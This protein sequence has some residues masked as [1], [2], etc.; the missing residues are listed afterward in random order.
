[1]L[2]WNMTHY[3]VELTTGPAIHH[4]RPA[5]DVLFDSAVK[6]GAGAQTLAILLTGMGADGADGMLKLLK[7][8]AATV[9]QNEETCV[10]FGMP[11]EAIRMGAAQQVLPLDKIAASIERFADSPSNGKT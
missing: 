4:Q 6:A 10:V 1:M 2:K 5:V 8:G 7:A 11:R 9:A 3:R